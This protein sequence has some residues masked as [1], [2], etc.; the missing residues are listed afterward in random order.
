MHKLELQGTLDRDGLVD[1]G[2]GLPGI[3]LNYALAGGL[4]GSFWA[5]CLVTQGKRGQEIPISIF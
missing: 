4:L 3:R 2:L 5:G 1:Y